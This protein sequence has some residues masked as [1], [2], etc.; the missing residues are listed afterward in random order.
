ML[1]KADLDSHKCATGSPSRCMRR[2][3]ISA[4]LIVRKFC[5]PMP[6][7]DGRMRSSAP[8]SALPRY[9]WWIAVG[10]GAK[11]GA[12]TPPGVTRED[13][14]GVRRSSWLVDGCSWWANGRLTTNRDRAVATVEEEYFPW[15]N[16]GEATAEFIKPRLHSPLAATHISRLFPSWFM[17]QLQ[18]RGVSLSGRCRTLTLVFYAYI[19]ARGGDH[20][21][22]DGYA[23]VQTQSSHHAAMCIDRASLPVGEEHGSAN[24]F[25]SAVIAVWWRWG[26]VL[27][28]GRR[29][30]DWSGRTNH[31][32]PRGRLPRLW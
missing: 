2:A 13:S 22:G 4:W 29:L 27:G 15:V 1:I 16:G 11:A 7:A 9:K 10:K 5:S 23:S 21:L 19:P 32:R 3:K 8:T 24:C 20:A 14:P 28:H 17:R 31:C 25:G 30:G 18:H 12:A 6:K 26:F